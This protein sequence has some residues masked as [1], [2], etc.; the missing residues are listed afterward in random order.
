MVVQ[1]A[2]QEKEIRVCF[3]DCGESNF[4]LP[5]IKDIHLLVAWS[6]NWDKRLITS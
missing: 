5:E 2:I 4:S 1:M 6:Q 3:L